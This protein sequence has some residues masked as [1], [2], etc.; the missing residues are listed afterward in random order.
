MTIVENFRL[1]L[2]LLATIGSGLSAGIFYAFS[3]FVMQALAKQPVIV[4]YYLL[5]LRNKPV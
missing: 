4:R 3:T 5:Q 2:I 1:P